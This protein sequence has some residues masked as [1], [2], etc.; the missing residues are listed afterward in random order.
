MGAALV[1]IHTRLDDQRRS[2]GY[3]A[4]GGCNL[5]EAVSPQRART[6]VRLLDSGV[7][8]TIPIDSPYGGIPTLPSRLIIAAHPNV[9]A[10]PVFNP[11]P[12]YVSVG[13]TVWV[14]TS[15]GE[16]NPVV[17][18]PSIAELRIPPE[19]LNEDH[20][21]DGLLTIDE[22]R[23]GTDPLVYDTDHDGL[24]DGAELS[25]N[26]PTDPLDPDTD[27]DGTLD[28]PGL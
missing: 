22:I 25:T 5:V 4:I 13:D 2:L 26:P 6:T 18:E 27:G 15:L 3:L 21:R 28:G 1:Q 11:I 14:A 7:L 20:D 8:H 23:L 16:S 9:Q 19:D 12:E 24:S 10:D 17:V